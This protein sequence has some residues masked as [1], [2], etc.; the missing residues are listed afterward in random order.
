[1]LNAALRIVPMR[2]FDP[3]RRAVVRWPRGSLPRNASIAIL[4]PVEKAHR[5]VLSA[6]VREITPL[7]VPDISFEAVDSMVM[8]SVY[9]FGLHGYE[10]CVSRVWISLCSHARSV[11]E[12]GGNVGLYTVIGARATRGEYTVVEPVPAVARGRDLI[13]IDAEV[14][15]AALLSSAREIIVAQRSELLVEVLPQ[16]NLLAALLRDLAEQVGYRIVIIPNWGSDRLIPVAARDFSADLPKRYN[17]KDVLLTA[18]E[19][20]PGS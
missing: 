17:S 9:W 6:R 20:L 5:Q 13:K 10:G 1:M 12:I 2:W 16:S 11:L 19:G 15:E 4:R 14:I 3:F 18:A 8:D 7:D